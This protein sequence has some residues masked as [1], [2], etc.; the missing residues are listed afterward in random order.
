M[1]Y[2]ANQMTKE[3]YNKIEQKLDVLRKKR[4]KISQAIG[5]A[6]EHGDLKENSAYHAAKEEQGLNEMRIKEFEEKI[7]SAEIVEKSQLGGSDKVRLNS[8]VKIKDI[9][10]G[11]EF[12][13][14]VVSEMSDDI[15]SNEIS[16]DSPLG[17]AL[18]GCKIGEE[19]E[20]EI[21]AGLVKYK[22]VE[23]S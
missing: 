5:E 8:T 3:A 19:V 21:P 10:S 9:V 4:A 15:F 16:T 13:Y 2:M 1:I 12:T 23:L 11:K 22:I 7:A 18:I 20:A 17:H 6:R 14:Q